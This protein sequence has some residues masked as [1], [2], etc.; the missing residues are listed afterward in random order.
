[1]ENKS[2]IVSGSNAEINVNLSRVSMYGKFPSQ[3]YGFHDWAYAIDSETGVSKLMEPNQTQQAEQYIDSY[4]HEVPAVSIVTTV[5][6]PRSALIFHSQGTGTAIVTYWGFLEDPFAKK[7]RKACQV[8][9][10][11]VDPN[12]IGSTTDNG[13]NPVSSFYHP[14]FEENNAFDFLTQTS[15]QVE[16]LSQTPTIFKEE[17]FR[18]LVAEI[19]LRLMRGQRIVVENINPATG[20]P[21]NTEEKILIGQSLMLMCRV[22][23]KSEAMG[24]WATDPIL[25][26]PANLIFRESEDRSCQVPNF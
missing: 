1:M 9:Y 23:G 12:I 15:V 17:K 25:K 7:G 4:I 22:A 13:Y 24:I 21:F 3:R 14:Q 8:F 19:F 10:R 5:D 20:K 18:Q 16:K 26:V 2:E 6:P 11:E